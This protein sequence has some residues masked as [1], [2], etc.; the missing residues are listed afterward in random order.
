STATGT[1][2][3][4][5]R[6]DSKGS[7]T[8]ASGN[9]VTIDSSHDFKM[10]A[11][12]TIK[13]DK[14]ADGSTGVLVQPGHTSNITIGGT[15]NITDSIETYPDDNKDG[16]PDGPWAAGSDRMGLRF[17][18]PGVSTGNLLIESTSVINVE[19]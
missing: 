15:I 11:G 7:I 18:G 5:V 4:S 9:A 10:D 8:V 13:M 19:G 2:P 3:D 16:V 17:A 1:G 6:I 12:S 14:S